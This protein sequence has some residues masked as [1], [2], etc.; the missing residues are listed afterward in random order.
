M[1]T[2]WLAL[3]A[4]LAPMLGAA[5][6]AFQ[7]P[8]RFSTYSPCAG[9][10]SFCGVRILAEG[11]IQRD[12]GQRFAEFL[13]NP[14]QHRHVLPPDPTLVFDS[15]GGNIAG[16]IELGRVIRKNRLDTE[17]AESYSRTL[18]GDIFREEIFL[19]SPACASACI[20]AFAGGMS[21]TVQSGARLGI[22]QFAAPQGDIGDS[23]TQVTI[24]AL[25]SYLEE[26][27][28]DRTLLDRTSLVPPTSMEW[29]SDAEARIYSLDNTAPPLAHWSVSPTAQGDA[30]LEVLQ[31]ISHGRRVAIRIG[32]VQDTVVLAA[33]TM[34]DKIAYREERIAQFPLRDKPQVSLCA[35]KRCIQGAALNPW[36]RTETASA[37]H[38]QALVAF[39]LSDLRELSRAQALSVS[40]RFGSA[41]SDVSL[42]TDISTIGF[43][44]GIALLMRI[45]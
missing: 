21:R 20:I 31:P 33:T 13:A 11:V 23:A 39:S 2:Y 43:S 5:Q 34:L 35:D 42:S 12:T 44:S 40:D 17:V 1:R 7:G 16:A 41:L 26:M 25:A 9:S 18:D 3:L 8:M 24:V 32:I 36:T 6:T 38:F 45:K 29:L 4:L 19:Q 15:P 22:H 28:V 27:G 10:A 30:V 37:I 14:K